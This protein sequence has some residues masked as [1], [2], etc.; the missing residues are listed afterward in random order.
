MQGEESVA[1]W[2]LLAVGITIG[3]AVLDH[4]VDR[5]I[6]ARER[7]RRPAENDDQHSK[8]ILDGIPRDKTQP[9]PLAEG[10]WIR[11]ELEQEHERA[12]QVRSREIA[13]H[14][15]IDGQW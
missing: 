6:K 7:K 5:T 8:R 15:P 1:V 12:V 13:S 3:F 14:Y 4:L 11:R 10:A 9:L 2:L